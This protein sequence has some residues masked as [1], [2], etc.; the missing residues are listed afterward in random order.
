MRIYLTVKKYIPIF[1]QWISKAIFFFSCQ[2]S[3]FPEGQLRSD[4]IIIGFQEPLYYF[5]DI[6]VF[7]YKSI[8]HS[9][10]TKQP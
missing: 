6:S 8:H 9:N 1:Q 5:F 2:V 7:T 10:I 4:A 3:G